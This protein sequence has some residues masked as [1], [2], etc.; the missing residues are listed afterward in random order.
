[1]RLNHFLDV[2]FF[3]FLLSLFSNFFYPID[4]IKG[5]NPKNPIINQKVRNDL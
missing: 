5:L 2:A 1:M 3:S 4:Y